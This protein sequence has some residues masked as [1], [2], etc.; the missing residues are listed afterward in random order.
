MKKTK[1]T[2]PL[3]ESQKQ[4]GVMNPP[5]PFFCLCRADG[6]GIISMSAGSGDGSPELA[7]RHRERREEDR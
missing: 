3:D 1:N 4:A 5:A 6:S 7:G 2:D